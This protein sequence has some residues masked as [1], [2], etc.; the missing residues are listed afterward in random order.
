M[1]PRG[2]VAGAAEPGDVDGGI[3][4][5]SLARR[6]VAPD[7]DRGLGFLDIFEKGAFAVIAAPAA[8]LEQFGE[9]FQP[10]LGKSAPARD[11]V[12]AARHVQSMCHEPA[13]KEKNGRRRN[14]NESIGR[15]RD[16]LWKTFALSSEA[17]TRPVH[18]QKARKSAGCPSYSQSSGDRHGRVA[19]AAQRADDGRLRQRRPEMPAKTK[20]PSGGTTGRVKLYGRL[21]WMGARAEYSLDGEGLPLPHLLVAAGRRTFKP[22]AIFLTLSAADVFGL[23]TLLRGGPDRRSPA[24]D[25]SD[26]M[27]AAGAFKALVDGNLLPIRSFFGGRLAAWPTGDRRRRGDDRRRPR[28]RHRPRRRRT[29]RRGRASRDRGRS[30]SGSRAVPPASTP[31][32]APAS[33]P[34]CR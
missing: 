28:Q 12:A 27:A 21:G 7:F 26:A 22:P 5:R 18:R 24:T 16:I 13:R 30:S 34:R 33:A 3:V 14:G 31:D 2:S 25:L 17:R 11:D 10:L 6:Q 8:G 29:D 19:A 32:C 15:D 23:Q 4:R 1:S 9:I 20:D